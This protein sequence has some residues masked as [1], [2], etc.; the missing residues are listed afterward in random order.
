M[1]P[2]GSSGSSGGTPPQA[3]AASNTTA[4][5]FGVTDGNGNLTTLG[6]SV[7]L[8]IVFTFGLIGLVWIIDRK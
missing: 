5:N 4:I 2:T 3:A 6:L 1:F 8:S 7:V